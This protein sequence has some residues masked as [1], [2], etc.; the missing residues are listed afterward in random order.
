MFTEG[1]HARHACNAWSVRVSVCAGRAV[2][3]ARCETQ[4]AALK[5]RA[6]HVLLYTD[7]RSTQRKNRKRRNLRNPILLFSFGRSIRAA[8]KWPAEC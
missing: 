2:C 5:V 4:S 8:R 3:S 1:A 7:M 6:S